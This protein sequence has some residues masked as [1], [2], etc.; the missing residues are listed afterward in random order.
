MEQPIVERPDV[1]DHNQAF[2]RSIGSDLPIIQLP[3][4]LLIGAPRMEAGSFEKIAHFR[5]N[6]V[7][8]EKLEPRLPRGPPCATPISYFPG[9]WPTTRSRLCRS[10]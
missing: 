3:E 5:S 4:A 7:I 10:S 1:G 8:N 6:I 2:R 9:Q